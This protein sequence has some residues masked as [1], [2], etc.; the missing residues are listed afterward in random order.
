[1]NIFDLMDVSSEVFGMFTVG[2]YIFLLAMA[3]SGLPYL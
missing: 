3:I 1:M 2:F